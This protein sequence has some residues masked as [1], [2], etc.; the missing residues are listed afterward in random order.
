MTLGAMNQ[1]I[2]A[3]QY[4]VRGAQQLLEGLSNQ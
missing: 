3:P 2:D 4:G 1:V